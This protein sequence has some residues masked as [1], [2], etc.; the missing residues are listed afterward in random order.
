[1]DRKFVTIVGQ[2]YHY[3]MKPFKVGLAVKLVKEKDNEVDGEAIKVVLP[4][5]GTIGY[6]ANSPRTVYNGT[7]SAGRL[8]DRMED[9]TYGR[10]MFITHSS[11][12]AVIEP[13]CWEEYK[14]FK[15]DD[16]KVLF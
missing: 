1:M 12:I 13:E 4:F 5:V 11:A 10:I 9:F 7:Y 16:E 14:T 3:G 8:Y 15:E 6:V 2:N